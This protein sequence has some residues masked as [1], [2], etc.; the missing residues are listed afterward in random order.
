MKFGFVRISE[1]EGAVLVHPTSAGGSRLLKGHVLTSADV[2]ALAREGTDEIVVARADL[3]EVLEN[4]AATRIAEAVVSPQIR[5]SPA[6]GGRVNVYSRIRGLFVAVRE[7]VDRLNGIDPSIALACLGDGTPVQPGDLLA[8]FKIIP[9]AV[10][11]SV[12]EQA[13]DFLRAW[14]VFHVRPFIPRRAALIATELPSLKRLAMDKTQAVLAARF[15]QYESQ[16][17]SERRVAH[18]EEAVAGAISEL[19][20]DHDL[21]VIF[22]ASAVADTND[23]VPAAIRRAGGHVAQVGMPVDPGNLIVLGCIGTLPIIGAP[24]CARSPAENGFDWVLRRVLAGCW[25]SPQ[26]IAGLGVG[27]LLKGKGSHPKPRVMG[28]GAAQA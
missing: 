13:Y 17:A 16:L 9:F 20:V 15:Q 21:V 28:T 19:M 8:T 22:G 26:E 18:A 3:G 12:V 11:G 23:V 27:G 1:A 5:L 25:P 6:A 14:P 7:A 4:E 24:G 10:A 2:A